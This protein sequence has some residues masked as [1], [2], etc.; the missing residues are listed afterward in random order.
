MRKCPAVGCV[1]LMTVETHDFCPR[2]ELMLPPN[3][4]RMLDVTRAE[5]LG[6]YGAV[7]V[8]A[9]IYAKMVLAMMPPVCL[10]SPERAAEWATKRIDA[11]VTRDL[12]DP[13]DERGFARLAEL[14]PNFALLL[15]HVRGGGVEPT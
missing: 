4:R 11:L 5:D 10:W 8:A 9:R 12:E 13:L 1:V 2:H 14:D 7:F 3:V 6:R 15:A